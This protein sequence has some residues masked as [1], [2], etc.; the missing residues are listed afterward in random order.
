MR[1]RERER[2]RGGGGIWGGCFW[3]SLKADL[4]VVDTAIALLPSLMICSLGSPLE[5]NSFFFA[6][7]YFIEYVDACVFGGILMN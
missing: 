7:I 2:G 3:L 4:T 1:E 6:C 5:L